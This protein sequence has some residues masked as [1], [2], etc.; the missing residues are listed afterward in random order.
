MS[1][2]D[3]TMHLRTSR[4]VSFQVL[5]ANFRRRSDIKEFITESV[6]E[7]EKIWSGRH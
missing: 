1:V 7:E 2:V 6:K 3:F 4:E 5:P